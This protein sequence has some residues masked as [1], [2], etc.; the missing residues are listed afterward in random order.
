MDGVGTFDFAAEGQRGGGGRGWRLLSRSRNGWPRS[1]LRATKHL[2]SRRLDCGTESNF[3]WLGAWKCA[4]LLECG[5]A[6]VEVTR[7]DRR[8]AKKDAKRGGGG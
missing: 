1:V 6:T 7:E 5:C 3:R 8:G 4:V 2:N